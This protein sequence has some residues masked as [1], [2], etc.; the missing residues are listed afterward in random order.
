[1]KF[2]ILLQTLIGHWNLDQTVDESKS[3]TIL[4][5]FV[6]EGCFDLAKKQALTNYDAIETLKEG[7][8]LPDSPIVYIETCGVSKIFEVVSVVIRLGS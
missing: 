4:V 7:K 6:S 8:V 2:L 5:S 1:M 3:W